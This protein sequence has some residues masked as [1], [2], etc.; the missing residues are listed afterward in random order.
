MCPGPGKK[1]DIM[2][3]TKTFFRIALVMLVIAGMAGLSFAAP[4]GSQPPS[5]ANTVPMVFPD[6][7]MIKVETSVMHPNG[8]YE[9]TP[10]AAG[11]QVRIACGYEV[12][13]CTQKSSLS[14]RV[15]IDNALF[16]E[17]E[18]AWIPA[19]NNPPNCI[20]GGCSSQLFYA[21][22]WTATAGSHTI[23]CILDS[24]N[25][26]VEGPQNEFNNAK[27][28]T[29]NVPWPR[30]DKMKDIQTKPPLPIPVPRAR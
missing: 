13:G 22:T 23:K 6:V 15:D 14:N 2:K 12:C 9:L 7:R 1:E 11:D 24:K 25:D 28:I 19:G 17:K 30:I 21:G 26:I 27:S 29:I 16:Y 20:P 4:P 8:T 18:G 10:S 3:D 5:S